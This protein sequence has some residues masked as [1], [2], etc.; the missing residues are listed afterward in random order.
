MKEVSSKTF[1]END[2][3]K[4]LLQM[5]DKDGLESF[6]GFLVKPDSNEK[7]RLYKDLSLTTYLEL[8]ETDIIHVVDSDKDTEPS[9]VYLKLSKQSAGSLKVVTTIEEL[10]KRPDPTPWGSRTNDGVG[11]PVLME[12][13]FPKAMTSDFTQGLSVSGF[14]LKDCHWEQNCKLVFVGIEQGSGR[15]IYKKECRWIIT[16]PWWK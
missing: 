3:A 9:L 12:G 11:I 8:D 2:L 15:P 6:R 13:D 16:C 5:A 7:I 4:K 1:R 10:E 14:S